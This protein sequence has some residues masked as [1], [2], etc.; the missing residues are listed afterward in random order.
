MNLAEKLPGMADTDLK[1]LLANARRLEVSGAPRQQG[2]AANLIPLIEAE[3]KRRKPAPAPKAPRRVAAPKVAK[4][5]KAAKEPKAP[6]ASKA[7]KT[8]DEAV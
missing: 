3:M 4:A 5:P 8:A 1:S 7:A 2:D 6:K